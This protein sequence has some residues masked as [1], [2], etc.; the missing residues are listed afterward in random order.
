MCKSIRMLAIDLTPHQQ[1]L[2][3][4]A[5]GYI[6]NK[7]REPPWADGVLPV[8]CLPSAD[9]VKLGGVG[10]AALMIQ[11]YA[12]LG[13]VSEE[14]LADLYPQG[15]ELHCARLENYI[16]SQLSGGDFVHKRAFSTGIAQ[17]LRS[18][19]YTGEALFAVVQASRRDPQVRKVM[20]GL[21]DAGYGLPEQSHWM[22]YAACAAL[23][24]DYCDRSKL[25]KYL[26]RLVDRIIS[27]PTYR[28]RHEST[29]IACRTEALIVFLQTCRLLDPAYRHFSETLVTAARDIARTNL[30]LQ[31]TYYGKGQFRKGR[32]SDK[33]QIDY[34]QHNG[35][36]FL[37]WWQLSEE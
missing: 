32:V 25:V 28:D 8:L 33:V 29:P 3:W 5:V 15:P 21:L 13:A 30:D 14:A 12:Q 23:T 2:L 4:Q 20:E 19:Y 22:A 24:V 35:A 6:R 10:L 17:P 34:I 7:T 9:T 11:E 37:G 18:E 26:S 16:I 1:R 36:A 27:D 31:A